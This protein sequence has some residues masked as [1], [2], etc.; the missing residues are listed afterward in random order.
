MLVGVWLVLGA[1]YL[2]QV[3]MRDNR[4]ELYRV[5]LM[6]GIVLLHTNA[7]ATVCYPWLGCLLM[8]CVTGFVFI[9][10]YYGIRFSWCKLLKLYGTAVACMALVTLLECAVGDLAWEDFTARVFYHVRLTWFLHA[11]AVLM[12][13]APLLNAALEK[14]GWEFPFLILAFGWSYL[15]DINHLRPYIFSAAGF[16]SH[17]PLTLAGIYVAT[18]IFRRADWETRITTKVIVLG[19]PILILLAVIGL[20]RYNAPSSFL[21]AGGL[22]LLFKRYA[23]NWNFAGLLAPSMFAVYCLHSADPSEAWVSWLG[24]RMGGG[25]VSTLMSAAIAFICCVLTDAARR[26]VL[27]LCHTFR[28]YEKGRCCRI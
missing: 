1:Y 13:A 18:R 8:F 14:H 7:H 21:L 4:V 12:L 10:G 28:H 17:T 5:A 24:G 27:K 2:E 19:I 25:I 15:Y 11:Y 20:G 9:S 16:G 6:V 26:L 3:A 23:P 22:F